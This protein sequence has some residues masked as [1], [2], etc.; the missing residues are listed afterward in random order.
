MSG[1][2]YFNQ[3]FSKLPSNWQLTARKSSTR[4]LPTIDNGQPLTNVTIDQQN[5]LVTFSRAAWLPNNL[6]FT[7]ST[8]KFICAKHDYDSPTSD[9]EIHTSF[10]TF[11]YNVYGKS[12]LEEESNSKIIGHAVLMSC[13]WTLIA[14]IPYFFY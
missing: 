11:S 9:I 7:N 5:K 14:G 12:K 6:Q 13:S 2:L 4:Q 10:S 1:Y 3:F 8:Q